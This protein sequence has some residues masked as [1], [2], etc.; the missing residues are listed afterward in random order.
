MRFRHTE[1]SDSEQ[2]RSVTK[3]FRERSF[4]SSHSPTTIIIDTS[5]S[6]NASIPKTSR[7]QNTNLSN[8]AIQKQ[9]HPSLRYSH[10]SLIKNSFLAG[11]VSGTTKCLVGHPFDTIKT[12]MQTNLSFKGPWQCFTNTL[13]KEGVRGLYKVVF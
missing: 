1:S 3:S 10:Q 7:P 5:K 6:Q 2:R 11:T 9:A 4:V 13:K 12:R 8:Q